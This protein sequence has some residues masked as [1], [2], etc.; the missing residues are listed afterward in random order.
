[1]KAQF[2][3]L[4]LL[5]FA[6][7][8]LAQ[9]Q[10]GAEAAAKVAAGTYTV[11]TDHTQIAWG[12]NHLGF[13]VYYGIFGNPTGT[14]TLDPAKPE[15]A[16]VSLTIPVDKV[17][18]TSE[19]LNAHLKSADFFDT[20]KFPTATFKSTGVVVDGLKAKIAGDL[21]IKGITKPVVLDARFTGT[22]PNPMSKI[23]TVGFE[24]SATIKRSDY[25]ITYA[26]PVLGDE[27][28]LHI[29]AAFERRP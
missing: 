3:A 21:T 4:A 22:G 16:S 25:G 27:V 19:K 26:L 18:T 11:D 10:P 14:L 23:E 20:A 29:T 1:M 5:G 12:I 13:N 8:A 2:V 17:T 7:P 24:A 6:A 15:A 28:S 9:G